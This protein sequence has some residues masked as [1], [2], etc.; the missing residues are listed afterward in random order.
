VNVFV[1][2]SAFCAVIDADDSRHH[3]TLVTWERLLGNR[4]AR[5]TTGYALV[6]TTS[7]LQNRIGF[8]AVRTLAADVLPIVTIA[9]VDEGMHR[10]AFHALLV[11]GRKRLSLVDCVSFEAMRRMGIENVFCF[12]PHFTEQGFRVH[13]PVG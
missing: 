9:W 1:D 7:L 12:D 8:D 10:S 6:E 13:P 2:T 11:S 5:P 4:D 3:D